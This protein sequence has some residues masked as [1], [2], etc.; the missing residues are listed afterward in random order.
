MKWIVLLVLYDKMHKT[1]SKT[2]VIRKMGSLSPIQIVVNS[3]IIN[4]IK[5]L[6][7]N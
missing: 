5:L 1:Q 4:A 7:K 2:K 6:S 3:Q